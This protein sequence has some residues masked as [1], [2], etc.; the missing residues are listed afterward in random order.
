MGGAQLGDDVERGAFGVAEA[1]R[2]EI[3]GVEDGVDLLL[4]QP[5]GA[6]DPDVL[7]EFVARALQMGHPQ[8]DHFPHPRAEGGAVEQL[9]DHLRPPDETRWGALASNRNT[10]RLPRRAINW[11]I[12]SGCC[13]D[14]G[15]RYP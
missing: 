3:A 12:G 6:G 11:R 5:G 2:V 8:D 15:E 9:V 10:L 4:G 14:V 13:V 1:G 7:A